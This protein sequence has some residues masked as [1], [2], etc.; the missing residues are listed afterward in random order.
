MLFPKVIFWEP[1]LWQESLNNLPSKHLSIL[2]IRRSA[3]VI[4]EESLSVYHSFLLGDVNGLRGT[5]HLV[6][7][8]SVPTDTVL[9][10]KKIASCQRE[11]NPKMKNI[12]NT[13]KEAIAHMPSR[14]EEEKKG[15]VLTKFYSPSKMEESRSGR[16]RD[17]PPGAGWACV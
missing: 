14:N 10:K 7:V 1:Q 8:S 11:K 6:P 5:C 13:G 3:T 2:Q 15:G 17:H 12:V 4:H 16:D 9:L